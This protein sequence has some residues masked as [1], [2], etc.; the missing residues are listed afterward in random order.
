M[1]TCW[2]TGEG[3]PC[4]AAF[5]LP[6]TAVCIA[7]ALKTA[8]HGCCIQSHA[9]AGLPELAA[10]TCVPCSPALLCRAA[11]PS[12]THPSNPPCLRMHLPTAHAMFPH[13]PFLLC[14]VFMEDTPINPIMPY[15]TCPC[16]PWHVLF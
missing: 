4:P 7:P 2:S 12:R 6:C 14:S 15:N 13:P 9:P 11:C 3:L 16:H 10:G 1:T 8:V 5:L